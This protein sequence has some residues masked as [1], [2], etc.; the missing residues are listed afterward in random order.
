MWATAKS[1]LVE[2]V[3][4]RGASAHVENFN[5]YSDLS[6]TLVGIRIEERMN[7]AT[8]MTELPS[9]E[10]ISFDT[11]FYAKDWNDARD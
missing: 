1:A 10:N 7:P 9:Y 3:A 5:M 2:A 11:L 6:E 4:A 8:E